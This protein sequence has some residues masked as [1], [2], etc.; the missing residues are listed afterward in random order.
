MRF[1]IYVLCFFTNA[2][3][4]AQAQKYVFEKAK[5]GS[6]F[7]IMAYADDSLKLRSA[8]E[9]AYRKVDNL[10]A[11]FSD[12]AETSEI[13]QLCKK[14]KRG[15]WQRVSPELYAVLVMSLEAS[16]ASNGAFD[17]T[18]GHIVKAWR[19]AK[20]EKV[21]PNA[22]LLK[23]ALSKTG[24]RYLELQQLG[25]TYKVRFNRDGMLL[26]FGGI[27]KGYA[28][29]EVVR[30]LSEHGFPACLADAGGDLA[31]GQNPP[32]AEGWLVGVGLPQEEN[33]LLQQFL[34]LKNQAVATSGDMY[35]Y[36]E[37]NG[38][39]YS[40]IVNPKTGLGLT[41]QR[42]VT[43]VAPD[44][45]QADW[46]AT[47][48]SVLSIKKALRLVKS[49]KNTEILMLERYKSGIKMYQS[50]GFAALFSSN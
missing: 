14:A 40:H 42:N 24:W 41:H 9:K 23:T 16:K 33:R 1:L 44:G 31:I 25:N 50:A 49:Y 20:K 17:V 19:K 34:T 2:V 15:E 6:P 39:R 18:V 13:S 12:Y 47:A 29:Q 28:A 22:D 37:V 3:A 43:I 26:D 38:K 10:N 32:N 36:L 7:I 21:L 27:V 35:N 8:V 46:L 30:I 11:I 48:C 5:M 45:A 4:L